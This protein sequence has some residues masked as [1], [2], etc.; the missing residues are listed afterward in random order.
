MDTE[1][2]YDL[3]AVAPHPD[4]TEIGC[5]GTLAKLARLGYQ[6]AI[7]DLTNG[8]PTP[9]NETPAI[10]LKEAQRAAKILKVDRITL[11]LPNRALFDTFNAR[12]EL[13]KI[14]R[15][16]R[17]DYV[18]TF[19]RHTPEASPDHGI[20]KHLIESAIFYSRLTRWQHY[21]GDLKPWRIKRI[22]YFAIGRRSLPL[23]MDSHVISD[24]S[25]TF[26]VKMEALKAYK[27]Q[28]PS[29]DPRKMKFFEDI[30]AVNR[31][32][33]TLAGCQYGE[34]FSFNQLPRTTNLIEYIEKHLV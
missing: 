18:V 33:G 21:F 4:D 3:V 1:K 8:E 30:E 32:Y 24:I 2:K 12:V 19:D 16:Y 7:I 20:G 9:I 6:I 11:D 14:F 29:D 15:K 10:R 5:G 34:L 31:Y 22:F 23:K 17:P 13:A 26:S 28:F 27:S 25:E